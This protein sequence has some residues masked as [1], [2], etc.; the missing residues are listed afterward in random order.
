MSVTQ[1]AA[2][3]HLATGLAYIVGVGGYGVFEA[4]KYWHRSKRIVAFGLGLFLMA[5]SCGPHHCHVFYHYVIE[6]GSHATLS[7][8]VAILYAFPFGALGLYFVSESVFGF[9][10]GDRYIDGRAIL[11]KIQLLLLGL[12]AFGVLV[13]PHWQVNDWTPPGA[14]GIYAQFVLVVLYLIVGWFLWTGQW[15]RIRMS[16]PWSLSGIA[17][18]LVF[19]TCALTHMLWGIENL[20]SYTVA[21]THFSVI[22][23]F[24]IA[25]ALYFI[26]I[27]MQ[28]HRTRIILGSAL[29]TELGTTD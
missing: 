25:A 2:I 21:D 12:L 6:G 20:A 19:P 1:V 26:W 24:G 11:L 7:D 28:A 29:V 13:M 9:G 5:M 27:A 10:P 15:L 4:W 14:V 17:L 22:D 8:L 16:Q 3:A 23:T 18:A